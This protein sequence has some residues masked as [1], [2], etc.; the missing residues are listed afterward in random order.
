MCVIADASVA[1]I[2][3]RFSADLVKV[4]LFVSYYSDVALQIAAQVRLIPTSRCPSN[5]IACSCPAALGS[6][7][8]HVLLTRRSHAALPI[9][10]LA[11]PL[12]CHWLIILLP[13][14]HSFSLPLCPSVRE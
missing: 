4:D 1:Q 12:V 3:S 8:A 11:C 9:Y 5:I 10:H 2:I 6:R 13:L 14:I 7:R